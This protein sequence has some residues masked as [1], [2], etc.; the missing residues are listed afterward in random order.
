MTSTSGTVRASV[1]S[2]I[3][4]GATYT[5][6]QVRLP[7]GAIDADVAQGRLSIALTTRVQALALV[8]YNALARRASANIRLD[9][10]HRPGSDVYLVL[11]EERGS[12]GSPWTFASRG[13]Q[14]K[15][16]WMMGL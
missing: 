6:N 12:D 7:S 4:L 16:T 8:Q 1:G 9:W 2:H 14:A 13:A 5:R 11:N 3:L 15:V 10:I